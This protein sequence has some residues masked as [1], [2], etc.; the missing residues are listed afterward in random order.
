[1]ASE[2]SIGSASDQRRLT[3]LADGS[4]ETD[5]VNVRQLNS[6]A[7]N[8]ATALGGGASVDPA[9]GTF[10]APTY[11][12]G[13]QNFDNVGDALAQQDSVVTQQGNDTAAA[14]GGG[15]TYDPAT[16]EVTAPTYTLGDGAGG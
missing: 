9:T 8:A 11:A 3:N 10:T 5:A 2:V 14:L 6:V 7:Q 4:A 16:G 13:G 1:P 15:A 12:V